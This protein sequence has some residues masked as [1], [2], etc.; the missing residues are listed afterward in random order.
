M[1]L[2]LYRGQLMTGCFKAGFENDYSRV[3]CFELAILYG[4]ATN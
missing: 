3:L 2:K 1:A 4:V